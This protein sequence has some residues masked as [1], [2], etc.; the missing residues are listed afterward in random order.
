MEINFWA[1]LFQEI[2]FVIFPHLSSWD[3]HSKYSQ[4][5][6][7]CWGVGMENEA[8]GANSFSLQDTLQYL[9]TGISHKGLKLIF[10]NFSFQILAGH[11]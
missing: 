8:Q 3:V 7:G 6:Y 11:I 2:S 4:Y 1:T 5:K 9:S 10:F